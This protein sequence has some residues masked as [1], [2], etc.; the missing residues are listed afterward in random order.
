[1][2][3]WGVARR[4]DKTLTDLALMFNRQIQGW[5]S[6]Y[7]R[8]YK[9]M[10]YPI[11]RHFNDTLVRWAMRKYKRLRRH[12]TRARRFIA[13]VSRRQPYLF[14]HWRWVCAPMAG[15]WEPGEL[16]LLMLGCERRRVNISSG[17]SPACVRRER[18]GGTARH[19]ERH[20]VRR[21]TSQAQGQP[22]EVGGRP[23]QETAPARV[24]LLRS[25]ARDQGAD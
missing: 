12:K 6:Y 9:S 8:F 7:G 13:D 5:I 14:A 11:F 2:R 15:R 17:D 25:R 20:A 18:A 16:R 24:P 4:S 23:R 10:L 22:P 3:R 1:M 21:A 19:G